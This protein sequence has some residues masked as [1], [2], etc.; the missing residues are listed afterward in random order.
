MT[1]EPP[2]RRVVILCDACSDIRT[3]VGDAASLAARWGAALHG[4]FLDD[5]NLRRLAGLPF[6][7]EVSLSSAAPSEALTAQGMAGLAAALE[8]GMRRALAETADA[9][10]LEWTFDSIR[11]VPAATSLVAGEGDILM[12]EGAAREFSGAWRPRP[13][14]SQSARSFAG[15][16]L[17]RAR[18]ERGK[19][20]MLVL[21]EDEEGRD[22][23]LAAG[24]ALAAEDE[25]VVVVTRDGAG[26]AEEAI[27]DAFGA[28][29]PRLKLLPAAKRQAALM[30]EIGRHDPALV[31]LAAGEA[32][33]PLLEDLLAEGRRDVLLVR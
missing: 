3:A 24:A 2:F 14:F 25:D 5:E 30:R 17:V 13:A 26:G 23:V 1:D 32:E 6:G 20:V 18:S 22:A 7:R 21:P 27:A 29:R 31:V 15:T 16:V 4:V 33:E 28:N 8:S 10:G 11:D 19:G 12:L 9:L